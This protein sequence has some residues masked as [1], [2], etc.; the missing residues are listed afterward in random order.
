MT[1]APDAGRDRVPR[2]RAKLAIAETSPRRRSECDEADPDVNEPGRRADGKDCAAKRREHGRASLPR[3][4]PGPK[5]EVDREKLRRIFS[6]HEV[7]GARI[8]RH[9]ER[10]HRRS[11]RRQKQSAEPVSG[12][13]RQHP[14][15]AEYDTHAETV[16]HIAGVARFDVFNIDE[17]SFQPAGRFRGSRAEPSSRRVRD[18]GRQRRVRQHARAA[19]RHDASLQRHV[20]EIVQII[21]DR[22]DL[23]RFEHEGAVG[24]EALHVERV[25]V[26][27]LRRRPPD[28]HAGAGKGERQ[29]R[30]TDEVMRAFL[31]GQRPNRRARERDDE[32]HR[33]QSR[34]S[35]TRRR[36]NSG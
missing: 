3:R 13:T 27:R 24:R 30:Q 32:D 1:S 36:G 12:K 5:R 16:G 29:H 20:V 21:P 25:L 34:Q 10:E 15:D 8:K 18:H 2:E 31:M 11:G 22:S 4:Q 35:P 19:H 14:Q 26:D 28:P 6:R 9:D 33:Q 7:N 17:E 23:A